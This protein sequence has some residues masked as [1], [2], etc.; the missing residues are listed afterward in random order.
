MPHTEDPKALSDGWLK[1]KCQRLFGAGVIALVLFAVA[2]GGDSSSTTISPA[3][4]DDITTSPPAGSVSAMPSDDSSEGAIQG[5]WN[6]TWTSTSSPG[7]NGTFH[8]DFTQAGE[9]LTGDITI[10][11]TPC[12]TTGTI[13]GKL[14]GDRITFGA[15]QGAQTIAYTGTISGTS[16][17][18]TYSAP[19]CGN[20]KGDWKASKA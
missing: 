10:S 9:Q 11:D 6:G 19:Q 15:V 18:G 13:T 8:I 5:R 7:L 3:V 20:G 4:G 14:A 12:I 16:M 1:G 2:C 17:S